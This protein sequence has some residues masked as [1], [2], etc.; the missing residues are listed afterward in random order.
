MRRAA[1]IA[2]GIVLALLIALAAAWLWLRQSLPTI[3][4]TSHAKGLAAPVEILRDAEGVPHLFAKSE[5]DGAFAMGYVHAQDRLWQ[6]E[7]QRRVAAG[8]LSEFLGE[9]SYDVDPDRRAEVPS[10]LKFFAT[11][12]QFG[13]W[14]LSR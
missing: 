8:R 13:K 9:R 7:F 10:N 4:G 2:L 14:L 3:D 6:M 12:G 11:I 5:R 1:K